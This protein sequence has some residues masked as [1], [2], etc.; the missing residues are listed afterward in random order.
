VVDPTLPRK[1][2]GCVDGLVTVPETD[3]GGRVEKTKALARSQRMTA[4]T[5]LRKQAEVT[6]SQAAQKSRSPERPAPAGVKIG[7]DAQ[8]KVI[9]QSNAELRALPEAH[10]RTMCR[11]K[12][13][14]VPP[15]ALDSTGSL[16]ASVAC[17]G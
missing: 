9:R 12:H 16:E 11:E 2:A 7:R 6:F 14:I 4:V 3:S 13:P 17:R 15:V 1:A 5:S 8:R 10:H